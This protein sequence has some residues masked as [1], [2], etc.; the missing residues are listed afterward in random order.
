MKPALFTFRS[1]R[2]ITTA[3]PSSCMNVRK[4]ARASRTA[5]S[6]AAFFPSLKSFAMATSRN[7][8]SPAIATTPE[9]KATGHQKN[10]RSRYR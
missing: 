2:E 5:D 3:C 10:G 4:N 1:Y 8:I 6:A 9:T 7:A